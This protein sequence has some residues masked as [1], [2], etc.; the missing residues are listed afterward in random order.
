MIKWK[1]ALAANSAH[2]RC[3]FL[4]ALRQA[5]AQK[6][7]TIDLN[8]GN[9]RSGSKS[10]AAVVHIEVTRGSRSH[11]RF[12]LRGRFFLPLFFGL[13]RPRFDRREVRGIGTG[14]IIDL[15]ATS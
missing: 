11:R 8:D 12:P 9:R 5:E 6:V 3:A 13:P 1:A 15:E 4:S 2:S 10:H 14:M 7:N